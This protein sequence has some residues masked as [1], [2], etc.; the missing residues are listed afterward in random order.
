MPSF[1]TRIF[2]F[3]L[4]ESTFIR[5]SFIYDLPLLPQTG[6]ITAGQLFTLGHMQLGNPLT[7]IS[8]VA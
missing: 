3:F 5:H 4:Q 1:K 8:H 2:F 7:P 6:L